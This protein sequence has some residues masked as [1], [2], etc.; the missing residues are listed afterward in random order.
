MA[1]KEDAVRK[2]VYAFHEKHCDK[3]KTFTLNHFVAE[4]VLR[5]IFI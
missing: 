4:G 5:F 2:C 3:P 1:S